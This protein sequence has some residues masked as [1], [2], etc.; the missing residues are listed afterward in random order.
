MVRAEI[1]KTVEGVITNGSKEARE[2]MLNIYQDPQSGFQ[3]VLE[4]CSLTAAKTQDQSP[5]NIL[6]EYS[7]IRGLLT[8]AFDSS[9]AVFFTMPLY[10]TATYL[11]SSF[12]FPIDQWTNGPM[13]Q[14][15]HTPLLRCW[16]A[17][18]ENL[19]ISMNIVFPTLFLEFHHPS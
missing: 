17:T 9:D 19:E 11:I 12:F 18:C 10:L 5:Q 8:L 13:D 7:V 2:A 16:V 3:Q 15:R 14:C 6:F 4:E 1:W